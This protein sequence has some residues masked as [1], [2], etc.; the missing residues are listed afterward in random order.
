MSRPQALTP[1][2]L[3]QLRRLKFARRELVRQ[4][5]SLPSRAE[6]A[7]IMGVSERTIGR[8]L[9]ERERRAP[10]LMSLRELFA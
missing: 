8:A 4:L 6:L 5:K 3:R 10:K 2:Q 7:R 1:S 9:G